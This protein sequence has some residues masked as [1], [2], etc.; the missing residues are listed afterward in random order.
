ME[1]AAF[2]VPAFERLV[3]L[4]SEFGPFLFAI[5]F[6]LVVT[7]TAHG[8]YRECNTRTAPP[9]SIEE[10]RTYRLYFLCSVWAGLAVMTLAVGWWTY[11]HWRGNNI[12]QVSILNLHG[13]ERITA[14][15][16]TKSVPRGASTIHDDYL[17][18]VQDQPFQIGDKF[19]FSYQKLQPVPATGLAGSDVASLEHC[20]PG[21][22]A[23]PILAGVPTGSPA[24]E[25]Y[26]RSE[27]R[28]YSAATSSAEGLFARRREAGRG[29]VP[30]GRHAKPALGR[31]RGSARD[32]YRVPA[33]SWLT[34]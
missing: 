23:P 25:S 14:A 10:K 21:T 28:F 26:P 30:A 11:A 2:E 20:P 32:H 15:Y 7:R 3:Q 17:L 27:I 12:Y 5:L 19:A 6:I 18:I 29:A 31:R 4:A 34:T 1:T 22:A 33:R 13:D 16:Y 9:A 8:Y 24:I